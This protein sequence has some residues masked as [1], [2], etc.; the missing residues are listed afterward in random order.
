MRGFSLY[1]K[2]G[3]HDFSHRPIDGLRYFANKYYVV[4]LSMTAT[5]LSYP[6]MPLVITE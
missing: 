5:K 4:I 2:V 1:K 6:S 3:L